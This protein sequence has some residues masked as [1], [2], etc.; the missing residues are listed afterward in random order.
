MT[1]EKQKGEDKVGEDAME[2]EDQEAHK[3]PESTPQKVLYMYT[4]IQAQSN[5]NTFNTFVYHLSIGKH[6]VYVW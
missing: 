3:K 6:L 4:N 2:E 1:R 5:K